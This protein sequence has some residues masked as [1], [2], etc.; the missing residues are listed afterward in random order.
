MAS[1]ATLNK[2]G[3]TVTQDSSDATASVVS[4][5]KVAVAWIGLWLGSLTLSQIVLFLTLIFTVLQIIKVAIELRDRWRRK[6][7]S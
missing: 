4:W 3:E 2:G 7:G 1:G 6:K 5:G